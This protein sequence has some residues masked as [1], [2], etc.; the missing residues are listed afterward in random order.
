MTR[1]LT[2]RLVLV[3]LAVLPA[4]PAGAAQIDSDGGITLTVAFE[5]S[6]DHVPVEAPGAETHYCNAFKE[7]S[8]ELFQTTEGEHW[9]KR[10]RFFNEFGSFKRDVAW[11][12]HIAA[13]SNDSYANSQRILLREKGQDPPD[14]LGNPRKSPASL[15]AGSLPKG[16]RMGRSTVNVLP[17][18]TTTGGRSE[19]LS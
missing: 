7:F 12:F 16:L 9:I 13:T 11:N 2:H 17:R 15:L 18:R 5:D 6:K 14:Y 19:D 4:Y 3:S 1:T 8:R 10:V